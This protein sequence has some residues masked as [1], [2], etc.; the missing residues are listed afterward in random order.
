[1]VTTTESAEGA[2]FRPEQAAELGTSTKTPGWNLAT[3]RRI[4][5]GE[6][7]AKNLGLFSIALGLGE[8][9]AAES[10]CEYLG[11][12][13]RE[14]LMR[15]YGLREIATGFGI[16]ANRRPTEW[17]YGRIA[18]DAL[19]LGSLTAGLQG[20]KRRHRRRI[21]GAI[22]AVA[23]VTLLDIVCAQQLSKPRRVE[24]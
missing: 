24:P 6:A 17:I 8:L 20:A 22:G 19:D 3:E 15:L 21:L 2:V 4:D 9:V 14:G 5:D 16:M 23:G 11:L 12:G 7:L 18:G 1:M 13:G 10:L